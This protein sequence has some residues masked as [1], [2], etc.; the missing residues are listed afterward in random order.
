MARLTSAVTIVTTDGVRGKAGL[1]VSAVCSVTDSPPTILV[2]INRNSC[3]LDVLE[4]NGRVAIS[5][6]TNRQT[7]LA[8]HFAGQTEATMEE[9]FS[10]DVWNDLDGVPTVKGALAT[11]AG[12]ITHVVQEGTHSILFINV[13][14]TH[15]GQDE[16]A[17]AYFNRAFHSLG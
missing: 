9:R 12:K 6:L 8:R 11:L 15:L 16:Q 7:S 14:S 10:W 13:S 3:V 5:L 2:C 4:T 1:T 17:L